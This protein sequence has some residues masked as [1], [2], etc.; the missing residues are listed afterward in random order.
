MKECKWQQFITLSFSSCT[1]P[2]L[3]LRVQLSHQHLIRVWLLYF[4]FDQGRRCRWPRLCCWLLG[5]RTIGD[6]LDHAIDDL[7]LG[8]RCSI[9]CKQLLG[10]RKY[11]LSIAHPPNPRRIPPKIQTKVIT[12]NYQQ[13]SWQKTITTNYNRLIRTFTITKSQ[14]RIRTICHDKIC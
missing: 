2:G 12:L 9:S 14:S 13:T 11:T 10:V 6:W 8:S 1:K 4:G 5:W 3:S 7:H